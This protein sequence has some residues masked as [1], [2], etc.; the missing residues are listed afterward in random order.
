MLDLLLLL[1]LLSY[2]MMQLLLLLM[3]LLLLQIVPA[4]LSRLVM[5]VHLILNQNKVPLYFAP[6]Q[7]KRVDSTYVV[8]VGWIAGRDGGHLGRQSYRGRGG[9]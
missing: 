2:L 3:L 6:I 5:L 8:A 9:R 4:L 1:L 7:L